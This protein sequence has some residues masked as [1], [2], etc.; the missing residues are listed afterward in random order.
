MFKINGGNEKSGRPKIREGKSIWNRS[1]LVI[2]NLCVHHL[3]FLCIFHWRKW[4]EHKCSPNKRCIFSSG[5]CYYGCIT[6]AQTSLGNQWQF[7]CLVDVW[8]FSKGS[9]LNTVHV[10]QDV[11]QH[12]WRFGVEKTCS[13]KSHKGYDIYIYISFYL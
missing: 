12:I 11:L 4:I 8:L 5:T 1:N 9:I 6:D 2:R 3:G 10:M 13:I 7:N